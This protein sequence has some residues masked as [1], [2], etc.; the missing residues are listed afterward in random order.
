[1]SLTIIKCG[2]GDSGNGQNY[3]LSNCQTGIEVA[4]DAYFMR[5]TKVNGDFNGILPGDIL[6]QAFFDLR[7]RAEVYDDRWLAIKG[8]EDVQSPPVDSNI[9]T[10]PSGREVILSK[11]IL[12]TSWTVPVA[13]PN[14]YAK[15][16]ETL[17]CVKGLMIMFKD[18]SRKLVGHTSPTSANFGGIEIIDGTLDVQ[19][20]NKTD[21]DDAHVIVSYQHS[22]ETAAV[23][24]DFIESGSMTYNL[25]DV[26]PLTDANITIIASTLNDITFDV[27]DDFAG[28]KGGVLVGGLKD[29]VD[30]QNNTATGIEATSSTEEISTG[31]YKHNYTS[32]VTNGDLMEVR[33]ILGAYV[34]LDSDLKRFIGVELAAS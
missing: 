5:K 18:V 19:I 8:I 22:K 17:K 30:I 12:K 2:C 4:E 21:T 6:N 33:G 3:G 14:K 9:K 1:M 13:D 29:L 16:I 25:N 26:E 28:Y 27:R 32:P 15:K 7:F 11:G 31:L 10:Y 23:D 34:Q 24:L 20:F